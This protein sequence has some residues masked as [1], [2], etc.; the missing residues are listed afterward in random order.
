MQAQELREVRGREISEKK[1]QIRRVNAFKYEVK[2]QSSNGLYEVVANERGWVCS[3][4]DYKYRAQKCKHVWAV[5]F[6]FRMRVAVS[7]EALAPITET[8]SCVFCGSN[9]IRRD[10]VRHNRA[11][12]LQ[13]FECLQC[14]KYFTINLGF[15]KM[16]HNPKGIT[17]AMQLYF[18]GE[19]LRNTQHSLELLGMKVSHKTVYLW[20]RK[21]IGLMERFLDKITPDVGETWRTDEMYVKFSGNMKYVFAMMDDET[22]FR[23]SQMV[24]DHKGTSDVRPMFREARQKAG[25]KPIL[26]ISDGAAN[27]A[28][29]N[30]KEYQTRYADDTTNHIRDI[31]LDATVHNNKMERQNGEVR[32]REK[33]MRGLKNTD[34]PILR[35]F[36]VFHNY[37]RPHMG[38]DGRTP[39][40]AAG[41]QVKG[42]NKWLTIIQNAS[43][44]K[45]DSVLGK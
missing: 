30:K 28:E 17:M 27:F 44:T 10:G 21:Y 34:S 1:T 9:H 4:P 6:S 19:S 43:K 42:D 25:K 29:A 7:T 35:G 12:D 16:K 39:A 38:L 40:E 26:L 20:I 31:R 18:S 45:V 13:K 32:D 5:E 2:S 8:D 11:G 3:C 23:L 14:G 15:E 36:Q 37:I 22:R 33:V 41:I 24:A